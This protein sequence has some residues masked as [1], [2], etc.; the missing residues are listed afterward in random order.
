M[1][2]SELLHYAFRARDPEKL[3]HFY[4]D[5]FQGRFFLHPVMTGLGIIMVK[6]N[7]P[8]AVF[9]GLLEIWPWDVVWDGAAAVFR[10]VSPQPS[11]TSY[12]HLAVKVSHSTDQILA[13][14]RQRG[15]AHRM[16][17][18][19]PG[20]LIPVLDD[21]EGNMIDLFPNL[22]HYTVPPEAIC[23]REHAARAI[24]ALRQQF[25]ARTAGRPPEQGYPL[26]MP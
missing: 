23:S 17:P 6:L 20:L 1:Q 14:L 10:K 16:E 4:A 18:R 9:Q 12:G 15:L 8:E 26:L 7:H 19:G 25:A 13:E 22:D 11:P 2:T 21:P 24:A 3:G 5:L